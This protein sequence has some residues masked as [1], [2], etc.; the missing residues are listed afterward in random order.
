[1]KIGILSDTHNNTDNLKRALAIFRREGVETLI[2]CGDMT[3]P[4]TAVH[5]TGFTIIYVRGNMD[6]AP[7]AMRSALINLNPK[8]VAQT[9]YTG[10]I[11]GISV[12][13][14]HSHIPDK[15][16]SFIRDGYDY[17]FHGHTHRRRDETVDQTRII[18]PGALGGS[19]HEPRSVCI[20][21]LKTGISRFVEL[22]N[23]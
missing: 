8:N 15:V 11:A 9:H 18:N 14:T 23:Q 22:A 6:Y 7:A 2:H 4:E 17:V 16:Q 10:E 21:N 1:M 13:A 3:A 19:Q 12:A 20:L 5:L